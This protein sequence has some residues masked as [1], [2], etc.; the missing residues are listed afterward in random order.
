[1]YKTKSTSE[2]KAIAKEKCLNRY[3]TLI[4]ANILIFVISLI[5]V[6]FT[7]LSTSGSIILLLFNQI[8]SIVINVCLGLFISGKAYMYMNV[9][10][11]NTVSVSDIFYGMRQNPDKALKINAFFV[12]IE[13]FS[14][15][16]LII[17]LRYYIATGSYTYVTSITYSL[18]FYLVVN[19]YVKITYAPVFFL[20]HDFPDRSAANLLATSRKLMKGHRLKYFYLC[21]TFIPLFIFSFLAFL[22]PAL[23]IS[24]YL[25]ASQCAF[26]Q[27]L[28]ASASNKANEKDGEYGFT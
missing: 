28:I 22:I 6:S 16:P 12:L 3:G 23:W 1:M 8:I 4:L 20:L 9:L 24:V 13:Y 26:Y 21:V 15:L 18:I 10:Y 5:I 25:Y 19:I 2:L 7:S 14:G 27:D 11:S 17:F